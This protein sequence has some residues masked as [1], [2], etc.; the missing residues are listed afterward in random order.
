[1]ARGEACHL[2]LNKKF[3]GIQPASILADSLFLG[4]DSIGVG[5]Y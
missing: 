4:L 1:M 3:L 2:P 5:I